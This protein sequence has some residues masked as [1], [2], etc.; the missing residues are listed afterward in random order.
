MSKIDFTFPNST[1]TEEDR[2]AYWHLVA[3]CNETPPPKG[4]TPL[5]KLGEVSFTKV[6]LPAGVWVLVLQTQQPKWSKI[7]FYNNQ[8]DLQ[9][10]VPKGLTK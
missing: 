8:H 2:A 5:G 7:A 4:Y 6:S 1:R 10:D 3:G 9:L